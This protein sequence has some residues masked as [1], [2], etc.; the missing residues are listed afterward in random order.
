MWI[1]YFYFI[2]NNFRQLLTPTS[3]PKWNQLYNNWSTLRNIASHSK[4][5]K[6]SFKSVQNQDPWTPYDISTK[7]GVAFMFQ[8]FMIFNTFWSRFTQGNNYNIQN[9]PRSF[10]TIVFFLFLVAQ[11]NGTKNF[12]ESIWPREDPQIHF[13]LDFFTFDPYVMVFGE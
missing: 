8:F 12:L 5:S 3:I 6:N 7:Y 11:K 10:E 9:T 1:H 13:F 2:R 4:I